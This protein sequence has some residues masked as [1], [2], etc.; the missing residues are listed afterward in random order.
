MPCERSVRLLDCRLKGSY[1]GVKISQKKLLYSEDDLPD[2]SRC[3]C[4]CYSLY[5]RW[6]MISDFVRSGKQ[7]F[8]YFIYLFFL[9][10]RKKGF[11]RKTSQDSIWVS[12]TIFSGDSAIKDKQKLGEKALKH[13]KMKV[14]C[15][16]KVEEGMWG[17][18]W[19]I[20]EWVTYF[21]VICSR[22]FRQR[23]GFTF[24]VLNSCC[25]TGMCDWPPVC[26][27]L[28]RH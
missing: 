25:K 19:Q 15:C 28:N 18:S 9:I 1:Q 17:I 7:G 23:T 21:S 24:S 27:L 8:F 20:Y 11:L 14:Y 12:R 3:G 6:D 26:G 10:Q 13:W 16:D 5:T 22:V 2:V 4:S